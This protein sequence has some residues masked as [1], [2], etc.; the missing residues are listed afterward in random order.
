MELR[1]LGTGGFENEGLPFNA[2]LV[3]GHLLA[4][5]PPDILQSLKREKIDA[6]DIDTIVI[7]HLH[8]DHCFGLPFLLF[9]LYLAR[10]ARKGDPLKLF[11]PD[12]IRPWM[13]NLLGLAVAP[14]HPYVEWSLTSLDIREIRE[15]ETVPVRGGLSLRFFRSEH[16]PLTYSL[17]MTRKSDH[18]PVF[19]ATSDTKWGPRLENLL[20]LGGDFILCDSGGAENGGVHL[21][22]AEIE[23][24]VL[25]RLSPGARLVATHF[26]AESPSKGGLSFARAGDIYTIESS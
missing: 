8:G 2:F 1:I 19:V 21:S 25:P 9:N 14:D 3:D 12:G 7:T 20:A 10:D 22:P 16:S 17:I 26:K 18:S 5:T 23:T 11:A 15:D 6:N 13:R 4:E 24:L